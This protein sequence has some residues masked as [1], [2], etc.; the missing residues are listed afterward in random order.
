ML[1][2]H[3]VTFKDYPSISLTVADGCGTWGVQSA[4]PAKAS[5]VQ[6]KD[7]GIYAN[8]TSTPLNWEFP[9]LANFRDLDSY[10]AANASFKSFGRDVA[11]TAA[12][13]SF[14]A[15]R[16]L[17]MTSFTD[18]TP[19]TLASGSVSWSPFWNTQRVPVGEE[20]YC[21]TF[22]RDLDCFIDSGPLE[23]FYF[24]SPDANTACLGGNSTNDRN[25]SVAP[26][27]AYNL[28]KPAKA[29][30]SMYAAGSDGY[31]LY[32]H[33]GASDGDVN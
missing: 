26:P 17:T 31:I 5:N 29:T 23:M 10:F 20:G 16:P 30:A 18:E 14:A 6:Y 11:C 27:Q 9:D 32:V 33:N 4:S 15:T 28:T 1:P 12:F 8:H 13:S 25:A 7:L 19:I 22:G 3:V 2:S 24:P 21:C